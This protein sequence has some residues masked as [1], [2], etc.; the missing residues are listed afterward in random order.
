MGPEDDGLSHP[1]VDDEDTVRVDDEKSD[2][3]DAL[4][5]DEG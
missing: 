5:L 4:V 2:E 3:E 1:P